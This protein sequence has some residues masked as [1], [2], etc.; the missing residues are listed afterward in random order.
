VA[1]VSRFFETWDS[2]IPTCQAF[3]TLPSG[4]HPERSEGSAVL[5]NPK[6]VL[7]VGA[8]LSVLAEAPSRAEG[9]VEASSPV[10]I[11]AVKEMPPSQ[12]AEL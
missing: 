9:E 5:P 8:D 3:R 2:K 7:D 11:G 1:P 12:T 10:R 4:C 6:Q